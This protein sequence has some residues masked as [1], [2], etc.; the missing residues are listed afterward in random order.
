MRK[1]FF[2]LVL[3]AVIST[4]VYAEN[5]TQ[6]D[7]CAGVTCSSPP[8]TTCDGNSVKTYSSP[9]T[10]SAGTCTY[11]SSATSCQYG[12]DNGVC[13]N[14]YCDIAGAPVPLTLT[15]ADGFI[16]TCTPT[17]NRETQNFR[18]NL[19]HRQGPKRSYPPNP[20]KQTIPS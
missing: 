4:A 12:C 10:C 13:K 3:I 18:I 19:A 7:P 2:L 8:A 11:S 20:K 17:C 6:A 1:V 14:N 16:A 5:E 9:G 15:C